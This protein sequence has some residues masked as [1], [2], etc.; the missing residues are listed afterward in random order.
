[1][2]PN[3]IMGVGVDIYNSLPKST[4]EAMLNPA[5]ATLGK[6]LDGA[7]TL[8]C[9]PLLMIGTVSKS[10]LHKFSAEINQKIN[11]IPQENRDVSKLGL[12]VKAMEDARYQLS[13]DDIRKMY[14]NLISS[15][16][17]NRKNNVVNPRLA[18]V[19]AQFGSDEAEFLKIIYQQKGQQIP[20]GYLNIE[21]SKNNNTRKATNYLCSSD[22]GSYLSGKDE[23]IDILNSLGIIEVRDGIWLSAPIYDSRYQA[24]ENILKNSINDKLG[25]NE[26]LELSKC[27]LRLNVFGH[28]LCRCIFE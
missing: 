8:V 13:E 3:Q 17:D 2:D 19:V 10:L 11:G 20:L 27:Y 9:S 1:M 21:N 23:S 25:E 24:I 18:T 5:A 4:Q 14:V 16:V 7:A 6:A 28:S 15:T 12:V 26:R 22:D